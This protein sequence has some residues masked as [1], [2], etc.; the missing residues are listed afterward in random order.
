MKKIPH[1][2]KIIKDFGGENVKSYELEFHIIKQ[3]TII[4]L[5]SQPFTVVKTCM[6]VNR[7]M[8]IFLLKLS[9]QN[10]YEYWFGKL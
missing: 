1:L 9:N 3:P 2:N 6:K 8:Y 7:D 4:I 5:I 10:N